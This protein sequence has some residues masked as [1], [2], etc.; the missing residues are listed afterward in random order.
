[1]FETVGQLRRLE[2]AAPVCVAVHAVFATGAYGELLATGAE[3]V[4]SCDTTAHPSN[5][6]SLIGDLAAAVG[7][8]CRA[9]H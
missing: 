3:R 7:S 1:M 8:A 2:L 5:G 4:V 6:I 9:R